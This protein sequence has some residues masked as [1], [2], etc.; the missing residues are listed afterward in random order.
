V[1]RGE[2]QG[3]TQKIEL[4]QTPKRAQYQNLGEKENR[5]APR[6]QILIL[7]SLLVP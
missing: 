3:F 2:N 7:R 1:K 4:H 6:V 5:H